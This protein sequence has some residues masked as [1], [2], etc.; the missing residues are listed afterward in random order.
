MSW[1]LLRR[2]AVVVLL[3]ASVVWCFGSDSSGSSSEEDLRVLTQLSS[4]SSSGPLSGTSSGDSEESG[5][6]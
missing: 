1:R 3:C 5:G 2:L 6:E 4:D